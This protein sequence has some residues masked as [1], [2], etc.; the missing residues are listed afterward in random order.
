MYGDTLEVVAQDLAAAGYYTLIVSYRLAPCGQIQ[1]QPCHNVD[2]LTGRPPQQTD[3]IK[4]EVRALRA[5]ITHCNG[6]IG[7]VGGSAGGS[8]ALFVAL[9]TVTSSNWSAVMR[10]DCVVGLSGAYDFSDRTPEDYDV[11]HVDPVSTFAYD[12]TNYTNSVDLA[13]Q[14][15][16]SPVSL[17]T[18]PTLSIPFKPAFVINSQYDP[19]PFHQIVDIQCA[20]QTHSVSSSLYQVLTISDNSK[21]AFALWYEYDDSSPPQQ[22]K[23]R[24][25]SFLDKYLK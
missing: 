8:H 12:V 3:D 13:V 17:V 19:M 15:S 11:H 18:T 4:A 1:G 5:D 22:V 24:V 14:K 6:K 16:K 23:T 21:Q 2:A 25:I 10:P 7:V 20:F 9:D